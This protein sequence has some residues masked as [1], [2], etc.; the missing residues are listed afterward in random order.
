[1]PMKHA[2][3]DYVALCEFPEEMKSWNIALIEL[4]DLFL[5]LSLM[6]NIVTCTNACA[7]TKNVC[8]DPIALSSNPLCSKHKYTF[9]AIAG[10][11]SVHTRGGRG[12]ITV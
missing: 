2:K 11:T 3:R 10:S 6:D 7:T 8:D 5:L 4:F 1:L 12:L 9:L